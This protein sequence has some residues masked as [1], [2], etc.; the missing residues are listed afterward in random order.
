MKKLTQKTFLILTALS[1]TVCLT[2]CGCIWLFLP[3]ADKNRAERELEEK[4]SQLV[5]RLRATERPESETLFLDF[6]RETGADLCLTDE[7][8]QRVSLFTFRAAAADS[9]QGISQPFCFADSKEEYVLRVRYNAS[10]AE[11]IRAAILRTMPCAGL[12]AVLLSFFSA[13]IFSRYTTRP[14]IRIHK[15]AGKMAELDFSWYCPD[16]RDDEIGMLSKSINELS[17]RLHEALT[18]LHCRNSDLEDEISLEKERERR[19]ML[20][21]SGI[22]HELKTPLAIVIGQLEGMQANIGVYKDRDK[23]LKR[24]TQILQSLDSFLK[25]ILLVSHIDMSG[26]KENE[27]L[28]LSRLSEELLEEY[29]GF[30]EFSSVSLNSR[31]EEGLYVRADAML[32]KKAVGNIIGNALTHSPE[33]GAVFAEL[34]AGSKDSIR[35]SVTNAPAHIGEEHLEHVFEAFYRAETADGH[36]SGLGLYITR[37]IL[38]T[39]DVRHEIENVG[40]GV[41]FTAVFHAADG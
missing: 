41:R 36:G 18:E 25:E 30:A 27:V 11:E 4:T 33:N 37:M 39:Y 5:W 40:D 22:S 23:Y 31:I 35:L 8:G 34:L 19:R 6:M 15:I 1:L 28:N 2:A 21:F 20:F 38:E 14:I 12:L 9:F 17:D 29:A 10:R 7:Q 24:S 16:E 3:Y 32:L 13:W 26:G